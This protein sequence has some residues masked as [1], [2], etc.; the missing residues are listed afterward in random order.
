MRE[1]GG[2]PRRALVFLAYMRAREELG[3][4]GKI[5]R[6]T[7][8]DVFDM[9]DSD[10]HNALQLAS[11]IGLEEFGQVIVG[12]LTAKDSITIALNEWQPVPFTQASLRAAHKAGT[13]CWAHVLGAA[14]SVV[15]RVVADKKSRDALIKSCKGYESASKYLGECGH[16]PISKRQKLPPG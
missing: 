14:A 13:V 1:P 2:N 7:C 16:V 15:H 11:K 5:R 12:A 3:T 4:T 8:T 6:D 10:Q 9:S